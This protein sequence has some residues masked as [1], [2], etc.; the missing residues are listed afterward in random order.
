MKFTSAITHTLLAAALLNVQSSWSADATRLGAD[1]TPLGGEKAASKSGIPAW[2]GPEAP[3]PGWEPGKKRGDFWK[4]KSDAP[5]FSIDATNVDKYAANLTPGQLA[6]V[7]QLPGYKMN[8]Y[9]TRRTC[10]APDFVAENTKKNVGFAQLDQNGWGIKDAIV[11]GVP[12]PMPTQ[13]A[14]V[15]WNHKFHYRGVGYQYD[16]M[17]TV[18]SPRQGG[19]DWI[20]AGS[21]FAQ[22]NPWAAKGA[23]QLS[24]LPPVEYYVYYGYLA[25][26]AL[27]GQALMQ[28]G[29]T[30]KGAETFY[31]FPGQRRVR[32]MPSYSYDSPQIGFENQYTMDEP[33]LFTGAMD[34]FDWKLVG[35]KEVYVPYNVFG[36]YDFTAKFEDFAKERFIDNS[37][38]RYELHRVW[39]VEANVKSG[40]RHSAPKRTFYFDE[41]S[42]ILL[43][44]EDEDA[45]GKLSKVREGFLIPVFELGGACDVLPFVQY[46]LNEGRYVFDM[47]T[48][49]VGKDV[50]W[51]ADPVGARMK[52][53]FY[54]ADNLRAI[55]DR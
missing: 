36:A 10:G 19:S 8:V 32:R 39:V 45:Q 31:Y 1:L 51:F 16:R 41:D 5:L 13:G 44:G 40:V 35:K 37:V 34:R 18:V 14:E 42:W 38:R 52:S 21:E 11:P 15:M 26:A 33:Y 29:Y 55:S 9:P 25:P 2:Q 6:L 17:N 20:R 30:D 50:R 4:H 48:S 46:N 53:G 23:N 3:L 28:T 7:K 47:N 12:F 22:F 27:A 24:K 54:S 43:A 49:G